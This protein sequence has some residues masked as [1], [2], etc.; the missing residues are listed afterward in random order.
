M[1]PKGV[2]SPRSQHSPSTDSPKLVAAHARPRG[3]RPLPS[4]RRPGRAGPRPSGD[5]RVA[6]ARAA[7]ERGAVPGAAGAAR[8]AARPERRTKIG[9]RGAPRGDSAPAGLQGCGNRRPSCAQ[10]CSQLSS[11]HLPLGE[12]DDHGAGSVVGGTWG[13]GGVRERTAPCSASSLGGKGEWPGVLSA[14]PGCRFEVISPPSRAAHKLNMQR[15]GS[16]SL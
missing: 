13:G 6:R 9:G 14:Q 7:A 4:R 12:S 3:Q 5:G 2:A 16:L 11:R 10:R 1:A 15:G 8:G